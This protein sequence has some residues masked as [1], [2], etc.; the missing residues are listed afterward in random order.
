MGGL[1]S[2]GGGG[3]G[4]AEGGRLCRSTADLFLLSSGDV[5]FPVGAP[6]S[7]GLATA[8]PACSGP[9]ATPSSDL[10]TARPACSGSVNCR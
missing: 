1:S 9:G 5:T 7:S 10:A 4:G 2:G 8:R 6:P 3:F